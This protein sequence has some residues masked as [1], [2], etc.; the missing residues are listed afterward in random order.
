MSY[1]LEF[2]K[3]KDAQE[4][5]L[6]RLVDNGEQ[7]R[8]AREVNWLIT[9]YYLQGVRDFT[10]VNY[11][12]G[13]VDITYNS[14]ASGVERFRYDD[15]VSK[16]QAQIGRLMQTDITPSV[17]KRNIGLEDLKRSS[18]GQV[19]LDS[20]Y[21]DQ[22]VRRLKHLIY[23]PL[24]KYG[25]LGLST[26]YNP[27]NQKIGIE[28]VM[29]WELVPLPPESVEQSDIR[30]MARVRIVPLDWVK[31]LLVTPDK[32]AK[33]YKE[34][35]KTSVPVGS[36]PRNLQEGFYT[37]SDVVNNVPSDE[38]NTS[39]GKEKGKKDKTMSDV[40]KFVEVWTKTQDD[41]L[42][43]YKILAGGKLLHSDDWTNHNMPMPIQICND[44]VT[45]SFWGRSFV[46]MQIP[47]NVEMEDAMDNLFQNIQDMDTYGIL[48]L[49]ATLGVDTE[50]LRGADGLR[51]IVYEPDYMSDRLKPDSIQPVNA[52]N[53]PVEAIKAGMQVSDSIANQPLE[54]LGGD[55]PGRV[56]S[57]TGLGFLYETA[58]IPL[59]PTGNSVASALS[60]CYAASLSLARQQWEE[61]TLVNITRLDDS[62]AGIKMDSDVGG[63]SLTL[64]AIP[65]PDE[66][67]IGVAAM[68]PK[69]RQQ[70]IMELQNA[71]EGQ[72]IDPFEY[73]IE[74]RKQ[75]LEIPTG[76]EAEWQNYRRAMMENILLFNDGQ[77]PGEVILDQLD[78]HQIHLR[79]LQSFMARPEFYQAS[80]DVIDAFKKHYNRHNVLLGGYP[81]QLP[82]PEEAASLAEGQ[83]PPPEGGMPPEGMMQQMQ[84][85]Q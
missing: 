9:H 47:I 6:N 52:G 32:Q 22:T 85:M 18:I 50:I 66:V 33:V 71:L 57:Q 42:A 27:D 48:T 75:G 21:P 81:Q 64:N 28:V 15:V 68:M 13:T 25:C 61:G 83:V 84:Q 20:I 11:Q 56:D 12:T 36:V 24:L 73:R 19:V 45:G 41:K 35:D 62:L 59:E 4:E 78:M 10:G 16:L 69:S 46:S 76:S 8:R 23:P 14:T 39:P 26:W 40:V 49:P 79:V 37:F 67:S 54:L 70:K 1:T 31:E 77:T 80:K 43:E 63:M 53:F 34:M 65:H 72:I 7:N 2:P 17:R 74:A 38:I 58:N 55:A 3:N 30:G 51:K 82:Y 29:P 5:V 44:M 60:Q